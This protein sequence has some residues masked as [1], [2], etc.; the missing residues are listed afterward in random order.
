M[1]VVSKRNFFEHRIDVAAPSAMIAL[2]QFIG[3][4]FAGRDQFV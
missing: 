3:D 4:G 1:I 2:Q